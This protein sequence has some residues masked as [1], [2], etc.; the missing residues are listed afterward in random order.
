MMRILTNTMMATRTKALLRQRKETGSRAEKRFE[1]QF[2]VAADGGVAAGRRY[3]A[4][5]I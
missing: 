5:L 4:S 3:A 2:V 1:S